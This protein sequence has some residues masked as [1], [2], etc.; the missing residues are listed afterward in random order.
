MTPALFI[1]DVEIV[2]INKALKTFSLVVHVK[3]APTQMYSAEIQGRI[4]ERVQCAVKYLVD[5]GFIPDPKNED[6]K[7]VISGMC[8]P[9]E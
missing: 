6:W 4:T 8:H 2:N 9:P 5:E 7:C 1:R 3:A